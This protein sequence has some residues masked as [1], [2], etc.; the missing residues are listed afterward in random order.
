[1]SVI[2]R[3][4]RQH[5]GHLHDV[6]G[7]H[8]SRSSG[9]QANDQADGRHNRMEQEFAFAWDAKCALPQTKSLSITREGWSK[10]EEQSHGE[11]PMMPLRFYDTE[12]GAVWRDLV[13]ITL[14][15]LME[16]LEAARGGS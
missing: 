1:M 13:V 12:R 6:L 9:N 4:S 14:D 3:L 16:L 11:R 7:G 15:D 10:I 5:E 8:Q 2:H